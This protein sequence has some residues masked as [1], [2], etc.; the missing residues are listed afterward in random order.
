MG[1]SSS[2]GMFSSGRKGVPL[3]TAKTLGERRR[4]PIQ[5]LAAYAGRADRKTFPPTRQVRKEEM[6]VCRACNGA[7]LHYRACP[8]F[9]GAEEMT[10]HAEAARAAKARMWT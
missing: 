1:P 8:Y 2:G 6:K 5:R 9:Y 3:L 4:V 10:I 7:F